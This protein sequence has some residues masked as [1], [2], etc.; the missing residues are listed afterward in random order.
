MATKTWSTVY[1]V[2]E[3]SATT[4]KKRSRTKAEYSTCTGGEI[5]YKTRHSDST[6]HPVWHDTDGAMFLEMSREDGIE[7][8]EVG[9]S[10]H[11]LGT[12]D[13]SSSGECNMC[14]NIAQANAR[15]FIENVVLPE[16]A[17]LRSRTTGLEGFVMPPAWMLDTNTRDHWEPVTSSHKE[18][19]F[20][21]GDLGPSNLLMDPKT[22]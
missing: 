10:C 21:H 2:Y 15:I 8:A 16:L 11:M 1:L 3:L 9:Q 22:F 14:K 18:F 17:K 5:F 6:V 4:F 20:T 12:V 7:L 19:K 13:H